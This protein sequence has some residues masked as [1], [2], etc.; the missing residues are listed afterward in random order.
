M[1]QEKYN[2]RD[3]DVKSFL[4]IEVKEY[5]KYVISTRALPNIMDGLRVGARKI[6][7]AAMIG[8][9]AKTKKVKVP[10]LVGDTMKLMYNHGD[11]SLMNTVVQL[12]AD[13]V[14]LFHPLNVIGQIATLRV[15]KCETAA[16][17]LHVEK[18][19][20]LELIFKADIDLT[21]H[22]FEEGKLV[23]PQYLLPIIPIHLLW[24]T[25]SPG[26]G[27][28]FRAFSYSL[29]SIIDNCILSI[30][31]GS[32]TLSSNS[33]PLIPKVPGIK[34]EN[35]IYNENRNVWYNVGEYVF[36]YENDT[37]LITDLPYNV[38]FEKY[39]DHL[40]SLVDDMYLTKFINLSVDDK[41]RYQ[42][43]F[44][45]GRMKLLVD[46]GKW[47]FFQKLKLFT[48]IPKDTLN[49]IHKDGN[50]I[51]FFD[52]AHELIDAFVKERLGVYLQRKTKK[53]HIIKARIDKSENLINFINLIINEDIVINK[54]RKADILI[55]LKQFNVNPEVLD[56]KIDKLTSDEIDI[57]T[58]K[59][60]DLKIE[61]DYIKNTSI[62]EMYVTDLIEIKSQYSMIKKI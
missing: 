50:K 3:R 46:A 60:I 52:T 10:S 62:E 55:D 61:L 22:L 15:P 25:N 18:A 40:H 14:C 33:Y 34:H 2:I 21:E 28:S 13:H 29:D 41:I 6:I 38:S 19:K 57:L 53:I 59:I 12:C 17:Y 5:A 16:R 27:F 39:E 37:I 47:K 51:L 7:Y 58:Q 32:C 35:M 8:D 11:A 1:S 54:R 23:E 49:I 42:L 9:L 56:Q 20:S 44:P 30:T 24:R 36:N 45:K 26:F 31:T 48:K 43:Y 4:N